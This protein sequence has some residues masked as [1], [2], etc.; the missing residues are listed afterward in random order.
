MK[1][2]S[3]AFALLASPAL[4]ADGP[5]LSLGN[6]NFVV[7]IAFLVFIAVLL[8]FGVPAMLGGQLDA[9]AEGI[10]ADLD[11]ARALRED[12]QTILAD[13]ERK[14][15]EVQA[16]ADKIVAA[17]KVEAEEAAELAKADIKASIERRLAGAK[18][19]IASAEA[20][21]VKEVRDTA[22]VVAVGAAR[23]VIAKS[24]TAAEGNALIED[25]I[26]EV[27]AKLH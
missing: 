10:K 1:K 21:A 25:A 16:Q 20:A 9:R 27:G 14:H 17:A 15:K 8:K 19:Q 22:I 23:D 6:T 24:T 5:F 11:E 18:D 2:L 13:Y 7:L 26:K 12:A 3:V 4:A